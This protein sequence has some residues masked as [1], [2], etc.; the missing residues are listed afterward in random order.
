LTFFFLSSSKEKKKKML[1]VLFK[2]TIL[3]SSPPVVEFLYP[4]YSEG[5]QGTIDIQTAFLPDTQ[6]DRHTYTIDIDLKRRYHT[7][8]IPSSLSFFVDAPTGQSL[9]ASSLIGTIISKS[10]EFRFVQKIRLDADT[11]LITFYA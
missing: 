3:L 9:S 11:N 4:R 7:T 1:F 2:A 6:Q 5:T 8:T 10:G